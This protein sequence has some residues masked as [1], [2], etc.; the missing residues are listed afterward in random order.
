[1]AKFKV[2]QKLIQTVIQLYWEEFD[3]EDQEQWESLKA[4]IED[5]SGESMEDYPNEAPSDPSLWFDLYQNL[6]HSEYA[7]QDEDD[8]YSD[9]KGTTEHSFELE[10]SAGDVIES[11]DD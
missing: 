1:M 5:S 2:K 7:L 6:Y 4:R 11:S 3:T 10:N 9:R 8:W